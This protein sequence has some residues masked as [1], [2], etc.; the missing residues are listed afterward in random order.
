MERETDELV[1][2]GYDRVAD[3][4]AA[5]EGEREWPRLRRLRALL[6]LLPPGA[7]VL[8]L[9]CGSGLPATRAVVDAGHTVVGVD[10]S[11]EQVRQARRNVPEA[12]IV[13]SS[14]L[15]VTFPAESFDAVVALYM[16]DHLPRVEHPALLA[17]IH[18]WLRP[19][20]RL[21]LTFDTA[22]HP[23][24]VG[25]WLGVPMF[26]SQFEPETSEQLV[27]D[28]GFEVASAEQETQLEG[29]RD[30][31]FLWVLAQKAG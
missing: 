11:R 31:T 14:A 24:V 30:V 13:Q 6:E 23:G 4:Y 8:D 18:R 15:D 16:I 7:N 20:G 28:A 26:F 19:G 3:A 1:A 2:R 22:D 12:A 5:L 9:G 10:V 29:E 25:D 27:R 17:S 21:L